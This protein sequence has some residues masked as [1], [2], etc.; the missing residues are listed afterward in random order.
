MGA[1]NFSG[2]FNKNPDYFDGDG[3]QSRV[4]GSIKL[5]DMYAL[6]KDLAN[7]FGAQFCKAAADAAAATATAETPFAQVMQ[8]KSVRGIK[9]IPGAA[10]TADD[11][12]NA[13]IIVRAYKPDGTLI[14]IMG[15]LTTVATGGA[16]WVSKVPVTIPLHDGTNPI[17]LDSAKLDLPAGAFLTLQIT[18]AASGVVVPAG[19]LS[20]VTL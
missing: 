11:T 1:S 14:G 15:Q 16:N 9:Y 8:A 12:N 4:D 6:M 2:Q 17:V 5:P 13:T 10:L 3:K 7:S 20:V 18:K 19:V